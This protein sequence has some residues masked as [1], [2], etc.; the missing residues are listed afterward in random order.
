MGG[1]E[2]TGAQIGS[3]LQDARQSSLGVAEGK[4]SGRSGSRSKDTDI[5]RGEGDRGQQQRKMADGGGT[6]AVEGE[7][8]LFYA[9]KRMVAST[10]LGWIQTRFDMLTGP[11]DGWDWKKCQENCGDGISPIPDRRGKGR[12][13]LYP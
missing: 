3:L 9:D 1:A 10:N 13:S 5:S 2:I 6:Y 12:L 8:I 11:F 7:G 4:S